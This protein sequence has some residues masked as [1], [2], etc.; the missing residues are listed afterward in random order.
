MSTKTMSELREQVVE[1]ATMDEE[2]RARLLAGPKA[3]IEE[4]LG[5]KI[6]D[7]FT[8]EVHEDVEDTSH[9]VLPPPAALG[10][11]EL[12]QV[13]GGRGSGNDEAIT[14]WDDF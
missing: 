12:G 13:A 14:F 10:E 3:A 7:G 6:P 5:V 8:V 9:L 1:R 4:E 2:F 11:S